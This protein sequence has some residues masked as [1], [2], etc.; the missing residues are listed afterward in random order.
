MYRNVVQGLSRLAGNRLAAEGLTTIIHD[1]TRV[2]VQLA[3]E[4]S[5]AGADAR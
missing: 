1:V 2:N 4:T 5:T 3:K